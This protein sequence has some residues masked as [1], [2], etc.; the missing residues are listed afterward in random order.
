MSV[1]VALTVSGHAVSHAAIRTRI[2]LDPATF[3][4]ISRPLLQ[5]TADQ[6]AG[7]VDEMI[8]GEYP[9][10]ASPTILC[11]VSRGKWADKPR[12]FVGDPWRIEPPS[13]RSYSLRVAVTPE[14]LPGAWQRFA[15]QL[16][17][18]LAHHKMDARV[19]NNVLE[20]FAV[21]VSLEVLQRLGYDGFR[22]SNE[23]FYT[24][25]IPV[26]VV[27]ALNRREWG[28][29]G[30]YLRYEWRREP[31]EDWD[32]ATHFVGAIAI[33]NI[34]A[35]PWGRLLNIGVNSECGSSKPSGRAKY[36]PLSPVALDGFPEAV[37]AVLWRNPMESVFARS[38]KSRPTD[39]FTFR[40]RGN[41]V[42]LRKFR[43]IDSTIPAGFLPAD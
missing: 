43:K 22:E 16:A 34:A 28:N 13:A 32:Q 30:L 23:H 9:N 39:G 42:S 17:H 8:P 41:W 25:S 37:K 3:P 26:D 27:S 24:Q 19:D 7:V 33:R 15:F 11:F 35:F 18:E 14:V 2:V 10:G 31:D 6:V 1:L 38:T 36:C 20:T 4:K 21:A 29:V 5:E 40:E 12:A